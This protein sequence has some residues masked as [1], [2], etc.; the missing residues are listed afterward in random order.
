MG[1]EEVPKESGG[2]QFGHMVGSGSAAMRARHIGL[3]GKHPGLTLCQMLAA[4][5]QNTEEAVLTEDI[6]WCYRGS[7]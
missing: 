2:D 3:A 7:C 1:T 5:W 4:C 6:I